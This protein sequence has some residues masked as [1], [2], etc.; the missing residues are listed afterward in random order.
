LTI[1][2]WIRPRTCTHYI[3]NDSC[4][5]EYSL[6]HTSIGIPIHLAQSI[7]P[8]QCY[9][10]FCFVSRF[11]PI[12][13]NLVSEASTMF[14]RHQPSWVHR[15]GIYPRDC[16]LTLWHQPFMRHP[17]RSMASTLFLRR[18]PFVSTPE[19]TTSFYGINL[20]PKASTFHFHP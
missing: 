19:S 20:V 10:C 2:L 3:T 9:A 4:A 17:P 5:C 15:F 13:I 18:L 7:H 8:S 1:S 14:L 16:S 6:K 11:C 12:G